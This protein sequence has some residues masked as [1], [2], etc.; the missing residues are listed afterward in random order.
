M[1]NKVLIDADELRSLLIS[2]Y[3]LQALECGG[4]DNWCGYSESRSG[5][6][7]GQQSVSDFED[8]IHA[9][10]DDDLLNYV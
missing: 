5:E 3:E 7:S 6:Y 8:E 10:A 4:V 1:S 9:A 2:H